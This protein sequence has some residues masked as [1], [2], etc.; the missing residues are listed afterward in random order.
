MASGAVEHLALA[1]QGVIVQRTLVTGEV[2]DGQVQ[3]VLQQAAF[4][5]GGHGG[6]QFD[7]HRLVASA[8]ALDGLGDLFQHLRGEPFGQ[9][10][11]QLAEQLV[12]HALGF[13]LEGVDG[14]EQ[15]AC[16]VQH[17]LTLGCQAKA[18]LAAFTQAKTQAGFQLGHLR[19]D[20][21]LA[22]PQF[23]LGGAETAALHHGDKQAQQL[24][25]EV[26]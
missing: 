17:L 13:A 6:K 21:R 26:A 4:Q 2:A 14:A 9:A 23:A 7:L 1:K 20:G 24:Q 12:G 3:L 19:A 15:P 11:A 8:K 16:G 25:V 10:D 5:F 18:R 22:N